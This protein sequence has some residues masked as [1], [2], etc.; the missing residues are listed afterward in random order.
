MLSEKQKRLLANVLYDLWVEKRLKEECPTYY[1]IRSQ[2]L[3][4]IRLPR[5]TKKQFLSLR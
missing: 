2:H 1:R 4:H 3:R 5:I